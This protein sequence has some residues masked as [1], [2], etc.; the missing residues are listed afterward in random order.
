M[1]TGFVDPC[2]TRTARRRECS[3]AVRDPTRRDAGADSTA[4]CRW[5]PWP[6]RARGRP[7]GLDRPPT[8]LAGRQ[9]VLREDRAVHVSLRFAPWSTAGIMG[10]HWMRVNVLLLR[11]SCRWAH[12]YWTDTGFRMTDNRMHDGNVGMLK[13]RFAPSPTGH[14]HV[15]GAR[16]GPVQL[17]A[18]PP[19]RRHVPAPH[20]GH[21]PRAGTRKTAVQ[22][23]IDDLRWLGLEWDEGIDVGGPNGPYRQ[24]E[25][26]EIYRDYA[27]R[28]SRR[29]RR[30]TP[31]RR[32]RN[33]TPPAR[34]P[35][36]P[37]RPSATGPATL[38]TEADARQGP[39]RRPAGRRAVRCPRRDVT[40][41]DEV[42]GE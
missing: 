18:G 31:S 14:L 27:Q 42:F 26:L 7:P 13:T 6:T 8:A 41:H 17:P 24:S 32:P 29:A 11:C 37:S 28:C 35:R 20:R 15:G 19:E 16:D 38:P 39:R 3:P 23:I 10:R 22:K 12:I 9:L 25:R 34:R 4:R 2:D 21:R 40:I 30:T 1:R 33:W 36:P 5:S